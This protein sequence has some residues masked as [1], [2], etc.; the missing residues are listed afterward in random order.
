MP[1]VSVSQPATISLSASGRSK[2]IL[3]S[4]AKDDMKKTKALIGKKRMN[5]YED[6][7]YV[8]SVRFKDPDKMTTDSADRINGISKAISCV[9]L[10]D[11][12]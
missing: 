4:S 11:H 6:C 8:I 10:A 12:R 7:A 5:Q 1:D 3:S 2:G 9:A